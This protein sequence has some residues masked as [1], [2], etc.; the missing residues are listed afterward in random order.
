MP[1]VGCVFIGHAYLLG[2]LSEVTISNNAQ[3]IGQKEE[4]FSPLW[5]ENSL[6]LSDELIHA[7]R[8]EP[9]DKSSSVVPRASALR[10]SGATRVPSNSIARISL[11]CGNAAT[12]I[13]NVRREMPPNDSFT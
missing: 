2:I 6:L 4:L 7:A 11:A 3:T 5:R 13:W 1:F 12:L 9:L 10:T 8:C